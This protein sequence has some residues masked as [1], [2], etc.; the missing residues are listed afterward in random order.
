[1]N[2]NKEQE[3]ADMAT[4]KY[5]T[6]NITHRIPLEELVGD[7]YIGTPDQWFQERFNSDEVELERY[8]TEKY[9]MEFWSDPKFTQIIQGVMIKELDL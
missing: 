1:M 9:G 6:I 3:G 8:H 4:R 7:G 5:F 2:S